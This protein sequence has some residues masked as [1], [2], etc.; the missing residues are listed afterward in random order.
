MTAVFSGG[1]GTVDHG[2]GNVTSGIATS[3]GP[4]NT[5]TTYTL[6]VTNAFGNF[7]TA[8]VMVYGYLGDTVTFANGLGVG[9]VNGYGWVDLGTADTVSSPT[10]GSGHLPISG[11][12]PCDAST[13]WDE[14]NALCATGLVPALPTPT[15]SA[16]YA[17]YWGLQIGVNVSPT[18]GPIGVAYQTITVNLTGSPTSGLR[19]ELHRYGD[20]AGSNYCASLPVPTAP[21]PL[22]SFNTS[23]WDNSGTFLTTADTPNIDQIS[24]QVTSGPSAITVDELCLDN[25]VLGN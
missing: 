11:A 5:N 15:T 7:T 22:T 24:V 6:T 16:V 20:P 4:I 1:T 9:A 3:T 14:S 25:I 2:I 13:I 18:S 23:C 12:S 8:Q 21:V 19:I 17:A 10:C